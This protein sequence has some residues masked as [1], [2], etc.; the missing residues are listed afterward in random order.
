MPKKLSGWRWMPIVFVVLSS[1]WTA[2]MVGS[3]FYSLLF[4]NQDCRHIVRALEGRETLSDQLNRLV[5][6]V[7]GSVGRM[8]RAIQVAAYYHTSVDYNVKESHTENQIQI[9]YLAWF[10]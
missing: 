3:L 9:S 4:P 1:L 5:Q 10:E 7:T 6:Q 8:K 2:A